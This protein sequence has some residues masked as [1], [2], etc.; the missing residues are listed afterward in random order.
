MFHKPAEIVDPATGR[1]PKEVICDPPSMT[2]EEWASHYHGATVKAES[3]RNAAMGVPPAEIISNQARNALPADPTGVMR[4]IREAGEKA[5][6][7]AGARF[8]RQEGNWSGLWRGL[9]IGFL[10]GLG[11]MLWIVQ[12]L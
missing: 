4:Q 3:F 12:N 11:V 2:P 1:P 6:F 5:A 7:E 10:I 9:V 8:G